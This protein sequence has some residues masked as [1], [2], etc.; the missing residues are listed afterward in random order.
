MSAPRWA[1]AVLRR[2]TAGDPIEADVLVGDLD[3]AH[4]TRVARHGRGLATALTALE[5]ADIAVMLIRRRLRVRAPRLSWL[6]IRVGA[7]M[8][9]RYPV[10]TAVGTGS[11]ALAIALGA[12]AFAL[13]TLMLWPRL[14]LPE[15]DRIIVV[16]HH[17]EVSN[18]TESRVTADYL[19]WRAGTGTLDEFAASRSQGRNL[20][21]GDGLV[22]PVVVAEVTPSL[23]VM[24]RTAPIMGRVLTDDDV[25]PAAPPVMVLGERLWR[26]RFDA[27]P[28]IIGQRLTIGDALATVVGVMPD[29]YRFPSN[30]EIWQ[31]LKLEP[32]VA[33][34]TGTGLRIWARLKDGVTT[35]QADAELAVLSREAA[36]DWP[37]THAHL[38]ARVAPPAVSMVTDPAERTALASLNVA[39]CVLVL[40]VSG[41]VALLMFARA[42]TRESEILVRA[43]LGASRARLIAQFVAEAVVLNALAAAAGL[44]LAQR[45]M[46]W[47]VSTFAVV[48]N[49][50]QPLPFWITPSLP[51]TSL[52]YGIGLAVLATAMTGILPAVK[53]TKG[54]SFGLRRLSAGGGGIKFGGVWTVLI[55]AQIAVTVYVPSMV[56]MLRRDMRLEASEDIGVPT[57]RVLTAR[58]GIGNGM[59][60]SQFDTAVARVRDDMRVAPGFSGVT[61]ADKLPLMWNGYYTILLDEGGAAPPTGDIGDAYSISTAAVSS[62]FF[63]LFDAPPIAGR[64]LGAA[65]Y[66]GTV[67]TVVVNQSF[68]DRVLGGRN[69]I[70]RRLRYQRA[71]NDGQRPPDASVQ[72]WLEIVGVVRDLAMVKAPSPNTAGVYM[73]LDVQAVSS[74]MIAARVTNDMTDATNA[75]RSIV[76]HVDR[77]LRLSAVQPLGRVRA[78]EVEMLSYI[79]WLFTIL[80]VAALVLALSGIYAVMSFAVSR[81]TREIGIRVALGSDRA[82]VVFTILRR[83]LLQMLAGVALGGALTLLWADDVGL[84]VAYLAGTAVYLVCA[85]IIGLLASVA[86]ARRALSVDPI[87]ALRVE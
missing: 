65:D 60:R 48:A 23:F 85:I 53:M 16:E 8:L 4:Q 6:D 66:A 22:E 14:P 18:E 13:I 21:M 33:P 36:T 59:T 51:V 86:P 42:A 9:V 19:R 83:P 43:A 24:T 69:A 68:V 63:D 15:G 31:P 35:T 37:T 71:G 29:G 70:G 17:D 87:A 2:L 64:L 67:R 72:P 80:S 73:P 5:V 78:S 55:V 30:Y 79:A 77:S 56:F 44:W 28:G 46:V 11:L 58:L 49:D 76:A 7:R 84:S 41:N 38:V 57:D 1:S 34:R 81:R 50:G 27:D 62:D 82:R 74:V 32:S 61:I 10:L 39:A 47:G 20:T 25:E 45:T 26:R 54:V 52:A 3:E 40:L 12:T 75:L